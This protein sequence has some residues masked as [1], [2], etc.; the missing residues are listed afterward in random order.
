M[1]RPLAAAAV[2]LF[3]A[4]GAAGCASPSAQAAA[5]PPLCDSL[6][7]L[8]AD[9]A[10]LQELQLGEN[11]VAALRDQLG[12]VR[13]DVEQVMADARQEFAGQAERLSSDVAALRSAADRVRADPGAD[14]IAA[15]RPALQTLAADVRALADEVT[16]SC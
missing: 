15:V 7:Q 10:R 3:L 9:A 11:G 12:S 8:K 1:T 2:L 16:T 5:R 13:A 4:G 6:Q 14:T